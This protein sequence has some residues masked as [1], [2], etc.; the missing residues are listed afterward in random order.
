MNVNLQYRLAL[1]LIAA[2]H[3]IHKSYYTKYLDW[4]A[5]DVKHKREGGPPLSWLNRQRDLL[6]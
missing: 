6:L 1:L 4:S 3:L 2:A 5:Y